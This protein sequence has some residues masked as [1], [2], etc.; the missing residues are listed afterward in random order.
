MARGSSGSSSGAFV[1]VL[2]ALALAVV[3][4]FTYQA[5]AAPDRPAAGASAG[6]EDDAT[7]Q[8][9]AEDEQAADLGAE[10]DE[11]EDPEAL[12]PDSGQGKRVVYSLEAQR[13][14]LVETAEDGAGDEVVHTHVVHPSSVH[15]LPG[16][17]LVDSRSAE[18][19][20]SDGVPVQHVVR[21]ATVGETV[22]GFSSALDGSLPDPD[23]EG[24]G[25]IRQAPEDGETMWPFATI[26]VK[27]VVIP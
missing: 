10:P 1:A 8:P 15:P 3:G 20:G 7:A 26:G 4:F 25:G 5:A 17:Y 12:P 6:A 9:D 16:E 23:T 13:V 27:V 19:T 14:W 11:P 21:F 24:T 18:I 22:V 2:T